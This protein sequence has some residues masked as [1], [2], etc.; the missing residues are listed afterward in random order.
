[1]ASA[2]VGEFEAEAAL[3][4]VRSKAKELRLEEDFFENL[5]IHLGVPIVLEPTALA[6]SFP[7]EPT[8]T[9]HVGVYLNAT[10]ASKTGYYLDSTVETV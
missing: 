2:V 5:D 7:Q 3:S 6:G 9:P 8:A 4:F 10:T 1:M